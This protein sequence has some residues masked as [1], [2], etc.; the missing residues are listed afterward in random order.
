MGTQSSSIRRLLTSSCALLALVCSVGGASG[1]AAAAPPTGTPP[2]AP[3]AVAV[4]VD[5]KVQATGLTQSAA[6][7]RVSPMAHFKI[8]LPKSLPAHMA[9]QEILVQP[10]AGDYS[11]LVTFWY[12]PS[13]NRYGFRLHEQVAGKLFD[14][15]GSPVHV[16]TATVYVTTNLSYVY[17]TWSD[18]KL[19]YSLDNVVA[20]KVDIDRSGLL[21]V[22]KALL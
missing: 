1:A 18:G 4:L 8:R 10:H 19:V 22:V 15:A 9:L 16:G 20:R 17:V 5:Y 11:P 2:A 12:A 6:L 14:K 3:K 13:A 21:T 7:A